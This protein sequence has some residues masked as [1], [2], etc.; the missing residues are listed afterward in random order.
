VGLV[1][2]FRDHIQNHSIIT[3]LLQ[4][5]ITEGAKTRMVRVPGKK[6]MQHIIWNLEADDS[7][8]EIKQKIN[9]CPNLFFM[10]GK[11]PIFIH[12]NASDYAIE[13]FLFHVQNFGRGSDTMVND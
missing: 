7:F 1:N 13:G 2:Y 12:T 4:M 5:M 6:P 11:P 8:A 3:Q 10:D 9:A